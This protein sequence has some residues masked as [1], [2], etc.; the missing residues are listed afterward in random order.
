MLNDKDFSEDFVQK[1]RN[2][3]ETSLHKYG[4]VKDNRAKID[5]VENIKTRLRKYEETG[6]TEWLID[7]ANFCMMEFELPAHQQA[8]F[9]PTSSVEAPR[10]DKF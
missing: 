5:F 7:A 2:R 8:H 4:R 9:R 3:M 6:N 10:L 1:M